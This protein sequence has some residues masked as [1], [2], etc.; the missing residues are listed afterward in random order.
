MSE[1]NRTMTWTWQLVHPD[2]C[3]YSSRRRKSR[4]KQNTEYIRREFGCTIRGK[5]AAQGFRSCNC[6]ISQSY[7]FDLLLTEKSRT[8]KLMQMLAGALLRG[9]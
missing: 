8:K 4:E 2:G 1:R 6:Q 5:T 3:P 7:S 9:K